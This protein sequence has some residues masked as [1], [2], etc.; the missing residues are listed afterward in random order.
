MTNAS[1]LKVDRLLAFL[2]ECSD[3]AVASKVVKKCS[4]RER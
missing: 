4:I 1:R 2:V 3:S